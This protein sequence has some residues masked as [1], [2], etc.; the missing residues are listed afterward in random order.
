MRPLALALA[1]AS[2][3][4]CGGSSKPAA[5]SPDPTPSGPVAWK[6]M[7]ADQ[8][9]EYMEHTVMP[10]MKET[11]VAFDA[12]EFG[13]MKCKTCHGAG[14]EDKSFEMPNADLKP[15]DFANMDKL[16]EHDQKVA[17]WMHEV[18]VPEMAKLLGE[19]PY[20]PATQQGFGCTGCH[21]AVSS[22]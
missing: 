9:H 20:D 12:E 8:R 14:A 3:A 19:Q 17:K 15:L 11:F 22:K 6:D 16:D 1:L 10:A 7:N 5:D 18:V 21:T 2:V 4:A 13:E